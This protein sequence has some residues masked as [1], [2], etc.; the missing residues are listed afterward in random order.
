MS[1][2]ERANLFRVGNVASLHDQLQLLSNIKTHAV[3]TLPMIQ[4]HFFIAMIN[5]SKASLWKY[6]SRECDE[7]GVESIFL[8]QGILTFGTVNNFFY[9]VII[10][11]IS[12]CVQYRF[13]NSCK[14]TAQTFCHKCKVVYVS[15]CWPLGL[16]FLWLQWFLRSSPLLLL[17]CL[18]LHPHSHCTL[19]SYILYSLDW[20]KRLCIN[21]PNAMSLLEYGDEFCS[22]NAWVSR[23]SNHLAV[24]NQAN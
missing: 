24:S 3:L 11:S 22:T 6:S 5:A 13:K 23:L 7:C 16:Y 19:K 4:M 2:F 17:S 18:C 9:L 8:Q 14:H 20:L 12:V 1:W 21:L 15:G 10:F